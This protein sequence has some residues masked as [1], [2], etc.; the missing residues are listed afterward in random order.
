MTE[1]RFTI[2]ARPDG[3][4]I[5]RENGEEVRLYWHEVQCIVRMLGD[6]VDGEVD[7]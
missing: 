4:T 3:V 2:S 1:V 7:G 5:S 6:F